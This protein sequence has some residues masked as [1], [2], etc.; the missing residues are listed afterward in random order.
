VKLGVNIDKGETLQYLVPKNSIF[1]SSVKEKDTYSLVGCMVSPGFDF[2]DFEL[3]TQKELL[4][5][6]PQHSEVIRKLALE[7]LPV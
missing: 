4:A 6:Y 7:E 2:Q 3:F 1:G 5:Q